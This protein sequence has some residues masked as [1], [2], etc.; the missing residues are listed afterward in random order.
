MRIL[1][2]YV[3]N[4]HC[5][6][7]P[8][9]RRPQ[10][11]YLHS[12]N[13]I[14]SR[15]AVIHHLSLRQ[16]WQKSKREKWSHLAAVLCVMGYRVV[17]LLFRWHK[18]TIFEVK[19]FFFQFCPKRCVSTFH[20]NKIKSVLGGMTLTRTEQNRPRLINWRSK[21]TSACNTNPIWLRLS[22]YIASSWIDV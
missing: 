8:F 4:Y 16:S 7:G 19:S 1:P 17:G 12:V 22:S 14:F 6:G 13:R 2:R 11:L 9:F 10:P 20:V 5:E 3:L 21:W 15:T 18:M